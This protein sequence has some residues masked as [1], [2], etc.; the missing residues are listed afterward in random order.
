MDEQLGKVFIIELKL[1]YC[2]VEPIAFGGH[3]SASSQALF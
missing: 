3:K 1:Q 2:S